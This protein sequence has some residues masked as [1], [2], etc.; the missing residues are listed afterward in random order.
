MKSGTALLN[1]LSKTFPIAP[2]RI[3]NNEYFFI[4]SAFA[5]IKIIKKI[6]AIIINVK[7]LY[8]L[9]FSKENNPNAI[10]SFQ[11]KLIFKYFEEN[12]SDPRNFLSR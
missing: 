1:N 6:I 7:K 9:L 10:P 2:P 8:K 11:I 4:P 3:I 5:V 12:I